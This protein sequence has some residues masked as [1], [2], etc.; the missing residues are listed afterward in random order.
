[1]VRVDRFLARHLL[2]VLLMLQAG[3]A[4]SA[5]VLLVRSHHWVAVRHSLVLGVVVVL[6]LVVLFCLLDVL[7]AVAAWC[8]CAWRRGR[9]AAEIGDS[10]VWCGDCHQR[11]PYI[12]DKVESLR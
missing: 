1:M 3:L 8:V 11:L 9:L 10:L 5:C 7:Q 4:Y 12:D 2:D 6:G